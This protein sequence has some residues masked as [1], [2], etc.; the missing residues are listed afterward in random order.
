MQDFEAAINAICTTL[1]LG[2]DTK[3]ALD[4]A[5][6]VSKVEHYSYST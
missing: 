6:G 3:I 2:R 5:G 4:E 1:G